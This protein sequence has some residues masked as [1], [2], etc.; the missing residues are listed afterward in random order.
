MYPAD[1]KSSLLSSQFN[2]SRF[3]SIYIA[4]NPNQSNSS[5][6]SDSSFVRIVPIAK[7]YRVSILAYPSET[8]LRN[9][10]LEAC[11]IWFRQVNGRSVWSMEMGFKLK[12]DDFKVT[13]SEPARS[14]YSILLTSKQIVDVCFKSDLTFFGG[15]LYL[16]YKVNSHHSKQ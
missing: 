13:L 7:I 9:N 16:S 14:C 5:F 8:P 11:L 6:T 12:L 10:Q 3:V 2:P 4:L 1:N 15:T